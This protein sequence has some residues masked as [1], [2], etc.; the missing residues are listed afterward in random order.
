MEYKLA[1]H[2]EHYTPRIDWKVL[3]VGVGIGIIVGLLL[4]PVLSKG[5][6]GVGK[7]MLEAGATSLVRRAVNRIF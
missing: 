7:R 5:E 6:G 3:V 4:A 2:F 1:N